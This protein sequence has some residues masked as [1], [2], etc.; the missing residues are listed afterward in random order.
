MQYH[1]ESFAREGFDVDLLGYQGSKPH[2]NL[3]ENEKINLHLMKEPPVFMKYFPRLIAYVV[4][5]IYQCMIFGTKLLLLP[6]FGFLLM[7]NPPSIPTIFLGWIVCWLRGARL[8]IDWH[9]YGYTILGLSLGETHPLVKFSYWYEHFFGRFADFG[10]CVTKAMQEDLSC[11][12]KI[13]AETLYDRPAEMFRSI[14]VIEK[15]QLLVKLSKTYSVFESSTGKENSTLFTLEDTDGKIKSQE[16]RPALLISSTSWTDYEKCVEELKKLPDILCVITG[17][18]PQKSFYERQIA[19]LNLKHVKFCLPWLEAED[20][21]Q[22]LGCADLGV[23]LHK[24]SSGLDLPMKVVD[25]FGCGLPVC[26]I[27]FNCISELV[28]DRENGM[29]FTDSQELSKQLQELL[30]GFPNTNGKLDSMR[31]NLRSFQSVRWHTSWKNIVYPLFNE[32]T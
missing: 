22:L 13:R 23:C 1:A 8:V 32:Q 28:H 5:V 19:E 29:I 2:R 17:K 11:N 3:Y 20:Y 24:S 15:H 26:A 10:F 4:K 16:K 18:G 7:Q 31:S 27:K 25:M 12:W 9:N 30:Q 6:K 14:P 21:P